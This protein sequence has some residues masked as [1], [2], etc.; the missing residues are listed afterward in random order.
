[1]STTNALLYC[2]VNGIANNT[3]GIGRQTKTLLATLA[4][5]HHHLSARAGAF[6]PYL[7]VPE[8]GPATWGYNEDDLR[9]ARHVVEGLNGQVITLPYDTRRP[10]WQPDTWRQLSGE[11]ARAAGHLA[12]RHD[13]VLAI[14]VDTPFAGLA[15]HAGAH[16]SVEVLLALF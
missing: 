5:R 7:A 13:K 16:P 9:Y 8:P 1:M 3:N 4:R 14:G 15:H 12:D 6:T 10:F 11:A 2:A